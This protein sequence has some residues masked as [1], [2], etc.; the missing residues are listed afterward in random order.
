MPTIKPTQTSAFGQRSLTPDSPSV[1][2]EIGDVAHGIA[3]LCYISG[4]ASL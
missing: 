4:E 3:V 2:T 1:G